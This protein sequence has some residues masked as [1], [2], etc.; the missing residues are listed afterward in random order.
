MEIGSELKVSIEETLIL[1]VVDRY[2]THMLKLQ[3]FSDGVEK[4]SAMH[5]V[6]VALDS[7]FD[8]PEDGLNWVNAREKSFHVE[9]FHATEETLL[10]RVVR[11][12]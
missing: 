9:V 4:N 2:G 10:L 7:F 3:G 12:D 8:F 1:S 6:D 5:V 11:P